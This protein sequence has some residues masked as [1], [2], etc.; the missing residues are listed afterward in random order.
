[1]LELT[2]FVEWVGRLLLDCDLDGGSVYAQLGER[3]VVFGEAHQSIAAIAAS[4]EQAALLGRAAPRAAARGPPPRASTRTGSRSNG[5]TTPTAATRSRSR[6]QSR[7]AAARGR[8]A[9][10]GVLTAQQL[11]EH[12]RRC[13]S[14]IVIPSPAT[15]STTRTPGN[16]AATRKCAGSG[17]PRRRVDADPALAHLRLDAEQRPRLGQQQLVEAL[18]AERRRR[19]AVRVRVADDQ[20]A[21]GQLRDD[22]VDPG[23]DQLRPLSAR[24]ARAADAR[25]AAR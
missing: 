9:R 17:A 6:F 20:V 22:Q 2:T 4:A 16:G 7:G 12:G 25:S 18:V 13:P 24:A 1:M 8:R 15:F 5:P 19:V 14:A 21:V 10:A 11:V 23:V 3:G